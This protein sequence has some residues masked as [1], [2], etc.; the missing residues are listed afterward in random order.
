MADALKVLSQKLSSGVITQ[1]EH[2]AI[3]DAHIRSTRPESLDEGHE[4]VVHNPLVSRLPVAPQR[5]P[6]AFENCPP[7]VGPLATAA[8]PGLLG[9]PV[10]F[11]KAKSVHC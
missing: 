3:L 11:L 6:F 4:A 5:T 1:E 9:L 8:T 7:Q 2:D 10:L